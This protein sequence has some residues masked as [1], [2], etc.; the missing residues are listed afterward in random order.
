VKN[1]AFKTDVAPS[2]FGFGWRVLGVAVDEIDH[3]IQIVVSV[4]IE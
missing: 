4:M 3:M 2:I 1:N